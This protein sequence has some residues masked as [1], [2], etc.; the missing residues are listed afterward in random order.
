MARILCGAEP[1]ALSVAE[2]CRE[3]RVCKATAHALIRRG[4]VASVKLGG[5]RLIPRAELARILAQKE[6]SL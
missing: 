5:R 6:P 4:D 2:F 1:S 3:V